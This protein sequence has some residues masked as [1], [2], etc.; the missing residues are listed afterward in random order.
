MIKYF[1]G[2][3][4]NT[5][6]TWKP[7]TS[8]M[9]SIKFFKTPATFE[10]LEQWPQTWKG[11]ENGNSLLLRPSLNFRLIV[12]Q[13]NNSTQEDN[14]IDPGKDNIVHCKYFGAE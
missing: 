14:N 13:F 8:I 2:T 11:Y 3:F 7:T 5:G 4:A 9:S 10:K 1:S 12:N 6:F